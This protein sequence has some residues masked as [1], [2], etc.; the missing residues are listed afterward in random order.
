ME[1]SMPRFR[2]W[3]LA[4]PLVHTDNP[5]ASSAPPMPDCIVCASAQ[6]TLLEKVFCLLFQTVASATLFLTVF[7]WSFLANGNRDADNLMR[8]GFNNVMIAMEIVLSRMP[9]VSYHYQVRAHRGCSVD[10]SVFPPII[11]AQQNR[12][13]L[14]RFFCGGAPHILST[15][16]SGGWPRA[17]RALI[18]RTAPLTG[19]MRGPSHCTWRYL[20]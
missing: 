3:R 14:C 10:S 18:G 9:F 1:A 13:G 12:V 4:Q 2:A 7:Y 15:C 8:H 20:S 5:V 11:H 16:G 19:R 6:W 17:V